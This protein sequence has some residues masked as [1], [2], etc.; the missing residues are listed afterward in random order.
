MAQPKGDT[1]DTGLSVNRQ[2][3]CARNPHKLVGHSQNILLDNPGTTQLPNRNSEDTD[4][5]GEAGGILC[6]RNFCEVL[7]SSSISKEKSYA[8]GRV[9]KQLEPICEAGRRQ[10]DDLFDDVRDDVRAVP[11]Q[12]SICSSAL[13]IFTDSTASRLLD[14]HSLITSELLR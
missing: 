5:G 6:L 11:S 4:S 2:K 14:T 8:I 10:A 13:R 9:A 7:G 12:S 3:A 1:L